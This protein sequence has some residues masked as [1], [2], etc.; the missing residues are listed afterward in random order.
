VR[1]RAGPEVSWGDVQSPTCHHERLSRVPCMP[2]YALR[3]DVADGVDG[4][5]A[6]TERSLMARGGEEQSL[7][8]DEGLHR[9][10]VLKGH[11]NGWYADDGEHRGYGQMTRQR[12]RAEGKGTI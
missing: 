3:G 9:G 6:N 10:V 11:A 1:G 8:I 2:V 7:A 5:P 12:C 4:L